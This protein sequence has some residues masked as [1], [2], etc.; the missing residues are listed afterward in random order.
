MCHRHTGIEAIHSTS[1]EAAL[2]QTNPVVDTAKQ[3]PVAVAAIEI[4]MLRIAANA[5]LWGASATLRLRG[6][7]GGKRSNPQQQA[8]AG[9]PNQGDFGVA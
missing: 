7:W 5:G 4:E 3:E 6:K 9:P 8:D 2:G 1:R